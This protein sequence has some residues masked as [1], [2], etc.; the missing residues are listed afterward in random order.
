MIQVLQKPLH[1]LFRRRS[2]LEREPF[3]WYLLLGR[4]PLET[5]RSP[6]VSAL[7]PIYPPSDRFWA[8]PFL[9]RQGGETFV[10][11]EEYPFATRRGHI[12][13]MAIDAFLQPLG[14]S[15]PMS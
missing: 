5:L 10:F 3:Q 9:W 13:A 1:R 14:E 8:D 7:T 2:D 12:S 15:K 4:A 6:D 11:F